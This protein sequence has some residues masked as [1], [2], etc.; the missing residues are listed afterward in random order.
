MGTIKTFAIA[1]AL[2][3]VCL[4][5]I[6]E[7]AI[8]ISTPATV[9]RWN[10][11][12]EWSGSGKGSTPPFTI[13]SGRW[14]VRWTAQQS[15]NTPGGRMNVYVFRDGEHVLTDPVRRWVDFGMVGG[16]SDEAPVLSGLGTYWLRCDCPQ[17]EWTLSVEQ[18]VD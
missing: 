6:G 11:I 9:M 12:G 18:I 2:F 17:V 13:T 16:I 8:E 3:L 4:G 1:L 7:F 5:L 14:R 15:P 10:Q